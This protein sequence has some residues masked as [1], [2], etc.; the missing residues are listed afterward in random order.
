MSAGPE[1]IA[2]AVARLR[3]RGL[4]AFPTE[5][6][7]GLGAIATDERAVEHVFRVKGRP[8]VNPLIVHVSGEEMARRLTTDWSEDASRL[9]AAFWPGPLTIVVARGP[10]IPALVAGGGNTV[11]VRCP[12]HPLTLALIETLGEPIVGPSANKSGFVSPTSAAH[13]EDEFG[14]EIERGEVM[15]LDGGSCRAGIESTVVSLAGDEPEVLRPGVIGASEISRVLGR[16]VRERDGTENVESGVAIAAPGRLAS[17]YAPR[18]RAV[19]V[20]RNEISRAI[21]AAEGRAAVLAIGGAGLPMVHKLV[22]MPAD[23]IGYA[24]SL[25]RALREADASGAGLIVIERPPTGGADAEIWRAIHD[26]LTR[27]TSPRV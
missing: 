26:R 24:S 7:Y 14:A 19:M 17:H 27:A 13:V 4:V 8:G 20:A 3:E 23:A 12:A 21:A 5:T 22:V 9:A 6:V 16:P 25:Y 15:V 11:A 1:E 18:T 10:A 2:A